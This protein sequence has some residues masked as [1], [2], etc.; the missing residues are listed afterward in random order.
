MSTY[1][2]L[3]QKVAREGGI[4]NALNQP[5]S[6]TGQTGKLAEVV[7]WTAE[8]WNRIQNEHN[9]WRFHRK[10]FTST[11]T[12]IGAGRYTGAS[13]G[14]TDFAEWLQET[15]NDPHIY[16]IYKQS[17]GVSSEK[18]LS[19][20]DWPVFRNAYLRG[21]QT[22]NPP[23]HYTIDA[24]NQ[25]CL[26]P[27]PD[28]AYIVRGEYRRTPQVLSANANVPI[29]PVRF[30]N[31]IAWR[32][33]ILLAEEAEAIEAQVPLAQRNY[34]EIMGQMRRDLLPRVRIGAEPIA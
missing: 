31:V 24:M 33:V 13:W 12:T 34:N 17:E 8:A 20:I 11:A 19:Y 16:T 30:H 18:R 32:A 1:L 26:G 6:V 29:C 3:C 14:I 7:S 27:A 21:T 9:A 28:A 4:T 2:E 5:S 23:I 25:F 15:D 10:E 22:N